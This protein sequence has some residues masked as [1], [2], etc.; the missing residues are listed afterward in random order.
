MSRSFTGTTGNY[1]DVADDVGITGAGAV[2]FCWLKVTATP[3][4]WDVYADYKNTTSGDR[5]V[6][7]RAQSTDNLLM[8]N[9][10]TTVQTVSGSETGVLNNWTPVLHIVNS[11]GS[12]RL[13]TATGDNTN[14]T[15]NAWSANTGPVFTL[16]RRR[17]YNDRYFTGKMAHVAT[18]DVVLSEVNIASL[19]SGTNPSTVDAANQQRYW[20]LTDTSLTDSIASAVLTETGSV[21]YDGADNPTLAGGGAT[22]KSNP[23]FGP[24]GG[25]LAGMIG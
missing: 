21:A 3:A 14:A 16:G 11:D 13:V 5:G 25:P 9:Y 8:Y 19:T 23:L 1:L 2:I 17:T 24:F 22:G 12:I 15:A 10:Q 4:A 18:W 7:C 6:I 20:S